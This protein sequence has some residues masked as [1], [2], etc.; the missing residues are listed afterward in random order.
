[1]AGTTGNE[2]VLPDVPLLTQEVSLLLLRAVVRGDAEALAA[3]SD[4]RQRVQFEDVGAAAYRVMPMLVEVV[5]KHGLA[6]PDLARMRG[7]GRHIWASN[8]MQLRQ[9]FVAL[10]A[11]AQEGITPLLLKGGA[12]FARN[13]GLAARRLAADYDLLVPRPA[14]GAAARAL[15]SAGFVPEGFDWADFDGELVDS[16]TA[17]A[18]VA[19]PG[20]TAGIDIHWRPLWNIEDPGLAR[21]LLAGAEPAVLQGRAVVIPGKAHHLFMAMARC[22]PWDQA[23]CIHRLIEGCFLLRGSGDLNWRELARLVA[24]Y[25]LEA[26]ASAFLST[27]AKEAG[28]A[29]P[30]ELAAGLAAGLSPEKLEEWAI[31]AIFPADRTPLQSW[32]LRQVE[33]AHGRSGSPFAGAGR[34]EAALRQSHG[35]FNS[36]SRLWHLARARYRGPSTGKVRFFEGFSYPERDGRWTEGRWAAMA[37]PLDGIAAGLGE[38]R[39]RVQTHPFARAVTMA[40]A[41]AG[42]GTAHVVI[43]GG[44]TRPVLALKA[45]ALPE[46]GGDALVLLWLPDAIAPAHGGRSQDR[47]T[48]GI[49]IE[50]RWPRL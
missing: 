45:M 38:I 5:T 18:S 46:L 42:A 1:M 22:E 8:M 43:L 33:A 40:S 14:L 16:V 19:L 36:L 20:N 7:V 34:E 41:S 25:G 28:I 6:D 15:R 27:L 29:V 30:P 26:P 47:R 21:T 50:R 23:E 10:D 17:A 9:L 39:L 35:R 11:L 32:T 49:Y 3:F 48:L 2:A 31:R 4:W 24:Q 12:L 37:V 13:P 44:R